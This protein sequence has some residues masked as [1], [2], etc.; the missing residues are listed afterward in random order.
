MLKNLKLFG[1]MG[2]INDI[3]LDVHIMSTWKISLS[4]FN[5]FECVDKQCKITKILKW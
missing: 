1:K 4:T 5:I 2:L 3:F